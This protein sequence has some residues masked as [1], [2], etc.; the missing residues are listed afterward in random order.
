MIPLP[1]RVPG[2]AAA[3]LLLAAVL[4]GCGLFKHNE[5][6]QAIV[7]QRV[8]GLSAGDFFQQFGAWR[9]RAERLDGT[10]DYDWVSAGSPRTD[11]AYAGLYEGTCRLRVVVDK[12]GKIALAEIVLDNPG[13]QS[14]SRCSEVFRAK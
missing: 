6:A 7:G 9:T 8:V 11:A 5:E 2:R 13:R 1:P 14:T 10:T 12:G 3:A 4:A